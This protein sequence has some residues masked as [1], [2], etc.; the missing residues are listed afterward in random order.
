MSLFS[1]FQKMGLCAILGPIAFIPLKQLPGYQ[2]CYFILIIFN[3]NFI[4]TVKIIT[5]LLFNIVEIFPPHL[6]HP[7]YIQSLNLS[8][9]DSVYSFA[10]ASASQASWHHI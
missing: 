3:C 4:I 7:L 9:F 8:P 10:L 6:Y 2:D 5:I 1:Q